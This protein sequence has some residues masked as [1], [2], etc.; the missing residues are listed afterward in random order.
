MSF[1]CLFY[2]K[3][4]TPNDTSLNIGV[5]LTLFVQIVWAAIGPE[6]TLL[7]TWAIY[8]GRARWSIQWQTLQQRTTSIA[9]GTQSSMKLQSSKILG[10]G[11]MIL[12]ARGGKPRAHSRMT[13][14][15]MLSA[16]LQG[17]LFLCIWRNSLIQSNLPEPLKASRV[18][19]VTWCSWAPDRKM[20]LEEIVMKS[21]RRKLELWRRAAKLK[22]Q[23]LQWISAK[24]GGT[25]LKKVKL[26]LPPDTP[27][28]WN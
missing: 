28:L 10:S 21:N 4:F 18:P 7:S 12:C 15:L 16:E 14:N 2:T 19:S 17:Q 20:R 13:S 25:R 26:I 27:G 6:T 1:W 3:T 22:M 9:K 11:R 23:S 8:K 5:L 24:F